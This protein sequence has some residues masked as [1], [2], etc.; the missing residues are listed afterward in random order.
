MFLLNIV[1][2]ALIDR[3]TPKL[4]TLG[5]NLLKEFNNV[6]KLQE[7]NLKKM[8]NETELINLTRGL[9]GYNK[10]SSVF[11]SRDR[12]PSIHCFNAA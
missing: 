9:N 3:L 7:Q 8:L 4:P 11:S 6:S 10:F 5:T 1:S 12:H 2:P